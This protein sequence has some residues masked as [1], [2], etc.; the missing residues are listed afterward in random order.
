MP[1]CV[2]CKVR[3]KTI[4]NAYFFAARSDEN[5]R[6]ISTQRENENADHKVTASLFPGQGG[7]DPDFYVS[8]AYRAR[9]KKGVI[10]K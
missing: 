2:L 6:K 4:C 10:M 1:L 9:N 5:V 7:E 3:Q 8:P